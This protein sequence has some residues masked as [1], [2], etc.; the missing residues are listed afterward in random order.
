LSNDW[1]CRLPF[2]KLVRRHGAQLVFTPMIISDSFV[3]S[4]KCRAIEFTT[5]EGLFMFSSSSVKYMVNL[6]SCF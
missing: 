3:K 4:E 1:F 5:D 6:L 2:R